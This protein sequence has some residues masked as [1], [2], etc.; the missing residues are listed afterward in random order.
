MSRVIIEGRE[1][2]GG[3]PKSNAPPSSRAECSR[4]SSWSGMNS[5]PITGNSDIALEEEA[6]SSTARPT[7]RTVRPVRLI[8]GQSRSRSSHRLRY[9][10]RRPAL[11]RVRLSLW[12]SAL[13]LRSLSR[14]RIA[15]AAV[16][17]KALL[18]PWSRSS[19]STIGLPAG[20]IGRSLASGRAE[21]VSF[22]QSQGE[23]HA[24]KDFGR[25]SAYFACLLCACS[26]AVRNGS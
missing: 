2:G 6:S 14:C 20:W 1:G 17:R 15:T 8:Q 23:A 7:T 10:L 13:C 9:H 16:A 5:Y 22:P 11:F 19:I 21:A 25:I 12:A 18:R 3:R 24:Q 4:R 26:V